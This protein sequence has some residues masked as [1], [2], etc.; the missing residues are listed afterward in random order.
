MVNQC[1]SFLVTQKYA[2]PPSDCREKPNQASLAC[3]SVIFG[4]SRHSAGA[5]GTSC[6]TNKEF[7]V[8]EHRCGELKLSTLKPLVL[9]S[10]KPLQKHLVKEDQQTRTVEPSSVSPRVEKQMTRYFFPSFIIL[11]SLLM[12]SINIQPVTHQC[13]AMGFVNRCTELHHSIHNTQTSYAV[14]ENI[15]YV[16]VLCCNFSC[17]FESIFGGDAT[18]SLFGAKQF[19]VHFAKIEW[20]SEKIWCVHAGM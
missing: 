5:G 17:H 1:M 2:L 19:K 6:R 7:A 13:R 4:G 16:T 10:I 20:I 3:L 14:S 15:H 8:A 11:F 9:E 18:L 12:W